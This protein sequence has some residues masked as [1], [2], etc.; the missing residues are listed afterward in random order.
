MKIDEVLINIYLSS[1]PPGNYHRRDDHPGGIYR[2]GSC[3]LEILPRCS[4]VDLLAGAMVYLLN[5][6][7]KR[8]KKI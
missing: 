6:R 1:M 5:Q 2:D 3:C 4:E 7:Q 8:D